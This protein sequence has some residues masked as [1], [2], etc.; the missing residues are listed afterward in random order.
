[1]AVAVWDLARRMRRS[2]TSLKMSPEVDKLSIGSYWLAMRANVFSVLPTHTAVSP[3]LLRKLWSS[4][5]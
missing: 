1:M 4:I 3:L 2:A 5:T